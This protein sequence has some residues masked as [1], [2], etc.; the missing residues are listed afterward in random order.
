VW[1]AYLINWIGSRAQFATMASERGLEPNR[2][3]DHLGPMTYRHYLAAEHYDKFDIWKMMADNNT[4]TREFGRLMESF[5]LLLVPTI[6]VRFASKWTLFAAGRG[7][8]RPVA[9]AA[10]R[11]LPL[12]DAGKRDRSPR[13]LPAGRLRP[14]QAADRGAV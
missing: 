9:R 5:D 1:S 3:E 11:R 14:G 13:S 7:G 10:L 2:H 4:V 12:Y 6:A 8:A